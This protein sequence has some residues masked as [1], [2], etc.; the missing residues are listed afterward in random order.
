MYW[1]SGITGGCVTKHICFQW[2]FFLLTLLILDN[3]CRKKTDSS[4]ETTDK[5]GE[6]KDLLWLTPE[7]QPG[8]YR[9]I[10]KI[11]ITRTIRRGT[12]VY[13][14]PYSLI[15]LTS[16]KYS[17]DGV[18]TY[19]IDDFITRNQVAGLLI[20]KN[21]EIVLERYAEGNT[22]QS[23]WVGFST[24]K[25]V[26]STLVGIAVQDG[27]INSIYDQVTDYL[28]GLRSTAYDGV[29]IRQLLQ[30]SSG[31]QWNEDYRDTT[32]DICAIFQ[33]ILSGNAGCIF[34]H[35]A[36]LPRVAEPGTQFLYKSGE[37][38]LEAEVL[39]A[40]LGSES[41]S[42]Y[43]SRKIWANMGM[44]ADGY[45]VLESENG[46]EFGGGC[47]SMTLRDYGRFGIFILNNGIVNGKA[48]L[49]PGWVA[50]ASTPA[51]DS[52]QCGYGK[53]YSELNPCPDPYAYPLGYGYNWWSM[54]APSWGRWE[55]LNDPLWWGS[56]AINAPPPDFTGLIGTFT[57]QGIFGQF[58]HVNQK[59]NMVSIIWSTWKDPW[60]DPKEYETYSFLNAATALLKR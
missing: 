11:F 13:P 45:W 53:L 32:S 12:D 8:T 21:G 60:I 1:K 56:D 37:T 29:T 25:S 52:P 22:A 42:D 47:L 5:I 30:M 55:R 14:L 7:Y 33:C 43:L 17:P 3:G 19:D 28:P 31:V 40:A 48:I 44:E 2:L 59:E 27:K 20:I 6:A 10:D 23:K 9:N 4:G 50:E 35:M 34:D 38:H 16:V 39:K 26:V 49:P 18:N 58:I 57:A 41:I 51:P 36:G 15:P 46:T 54:P 24:G